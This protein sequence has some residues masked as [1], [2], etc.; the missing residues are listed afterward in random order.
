MTH[1][2]HS[3]LVVA[4]VTCSPTCCN[5]PN[6]SRTNASRTNTGVAGQCEEEAS[7]VEP[8]GIRESCLCVVCQEEEH[9]R[10][11]DVETFRN[12]SNVSYSIWIPP[13]GISHVSYMC[14]MSRVSCLVCHVS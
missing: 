13:P 2:F 1:V 12:S 9:E 6:A 5:T 11:A 7:G 8:Y 10:E 3:A 4:E 14:V